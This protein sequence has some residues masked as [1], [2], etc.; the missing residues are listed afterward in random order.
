MNQSF[1]NKYGDFLSML[2]LLATYITFAQ[3]PKNSVDY[4]I[5][6]G[7]NFS[8]NDGNYQFNLGGFIQP[9]FSNTKIDGAK[10]ENQF[11]SRRSF[12]QFSGDAKREK[13]SFLLQLDYSLNQPL[14]DA[15]IAYHPTENI[16]IFFGQKQT[17]VNNREM[18]YRED[19]LQFT[20]RS[21]LSK[22]FSRTGREFGV[23]VTSKF[24]DDF[25]FAPML[26]VTSGDGRNSFGTDSRDTDLGGIKYGGRLDVYPLGFFKE[27]NDLTSSDLEREEKPKIVIGFAG[28]KNIGASNAV[29]EGHGNYVLYDAAGLNNYPD[30]TQLY[31]DFLVK[32][33]GF[34]FLAEYINATASNIDLTYTNATTTTILAPTQISEYLVL[35]DSFNFQLGYVFTNGF[36]VDGR[37]EITN[38]EFANNANSILQDAKAYTVG[39]SKYF[40]NNKLKVQTS[41]SNFNP[42]VGNSINQ[43]E[44][45]FQITF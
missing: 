29:G 33:Q 37:Y 30:Y 22:N 26:A 38:Q 39:I 35:G 25:G 45:L 1:T 24:G 32:Y 8:L 15:W 44:L 5:G 18:T 34:S 16:S 3:T 4:K 42:E 13:V 23:F 28:S 9:I 12:L 31:A 17:F 10:A 7:L 2:L 41:Y 36:S 6:D 40:V 11:N 20:D 14:L 27:G 21:F 43:F 19:R